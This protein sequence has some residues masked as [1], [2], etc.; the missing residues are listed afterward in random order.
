MLRQKAL[1]EVLG[2][3]NTA[4]V[5]GSL[6]FNRE[7]L[8][9]AHSGYGD[10]KDHANVSAAL[11]SNIWESFDKKGGREDLKEAIIL[12]EDGV[13]AATRVANMLLA[14]RAS[15]TCNLGV[16]RAKLH[17]LAQYLD[18]PISVVSRNA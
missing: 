9:L 17:A 6:L 12:C 1:L 18:G 2:Q 15:K 14:L 11:I 13:M 4:D 8:L 5:Y 10:S 7:G 3:V 16:L